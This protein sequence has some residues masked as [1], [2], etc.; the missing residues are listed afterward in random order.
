MLKPIDDIMKTRILFII[1]N[2][3][4]GGAE[5]VFLHLMNNLDRDRFEVYLLVL[6]RAG[7]YF[8]HLRGDVSVIDL[9]TSL[10]NCLLKVAKSIDSVRPHAILCTICFLN[11]MV[12]FSRLFVRNRGAM[13]IARES[14]MPIHRK[15]H[16]GS[17]SNWDIFYRLAYRLFDKLICQSEDMGR[18]IA[19]LYNVPPKKIVKIYNPVDVADL[20][21]KA[22]EGTSAWRV[23]GKVNLL[24]V[25][26]LHHVKGFDLL[27]E[28]IA[29]IGGS[30]LHF[31][32]L[33]D[34]EEEDN[35]KQ[36][37]LR[38]GIQERIS[39]HGFQDNPYHYMATADALILTSRYEGLPNV[40]LE[41]M[42]LGCPVVAFESP[43]GVSEILR[44]GENGLIVQ[45]E[46]VHALAEI[47]EQGRYLSL[48]RDAVRQSVITR[49]S[50]SAIVEQ[51]ENLF[52][53]GVFPE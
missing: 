15:R 4:C 50:V 53:D 29:K 22:Q 11:I 34:G 10:K 49:F 18:D 39:F 47:L 5:R 33:G 24:A 32:I 42:A 6:R 23:Q 27:L 19:A 41:A 28:A 2:L 30:A 40:V 44:H 21:I 46:N 31:H 52:S 37:S 12:G 38:L 51:Y 8:E 48:D 35:L 14:S 26:R 9:N 20:Q 36:Q 7:P 17:I 13:Y 43:G 3:C 45:S 25:G 1:P 16:F